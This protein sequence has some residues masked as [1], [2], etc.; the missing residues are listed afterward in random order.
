M[1]ND[2]DQPPCDCCVKSEDGSYH[3]QDCFC[4]NT[5]DTITAAYWCG[6]KNAQDKG[7]DSEK[8]NR[9]KNFLAIMADGDGCQEES[10]KEV[11]EIMRQLERAQAKDITIS[12]E[13]TEALIGLLRQIMGGKQTTK[14]VLEHLL[15]IYQRL[16]QALQEEN[17]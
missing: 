2:S 7:I 1:S 14:R 5:G 10:A 15:P 12:R 4:G 11:I 6:E 3:V 16:T 17:K 9:A 13:D 8:I